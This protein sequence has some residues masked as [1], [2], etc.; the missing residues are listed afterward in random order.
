MAGTV[1]TKVDMANLALSHLKEP[2]IQDFDFSS[3]ASRWFR[4]NY[5]AKRDAYL[6]MHDWDFAM[7]LAM[8]GADTIRPPFR[9]RFQ[10][11]L[12][13][14]FLRLPVQTENGD[15]NGHRIKAEVV[16]AKLMTDYQPPFPLRYVA[17]VDSEARFPPL[18][19]NGFS[20]FLAAGAAHVIAGKNSLVQTMQEAAE[21]SLDLAGTVD[22]EQ[23][24]PE[25]MEVP[26]IITE[27]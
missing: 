16:G 22:A 20:F 13:S 6:A 8:I 4:N 11:S 5:V 1:N 17:R 2:A 14:D 19:V 27:R 3:V 25:P 10:Y 24:T 9:W 15:H 26:E 12:P 21:S 23:S 18:F 7:G